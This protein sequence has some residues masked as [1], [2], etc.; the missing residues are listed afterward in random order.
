MHRRLTFL[1]LCLLAG[2][3]SA[4]PRIALVPLVPR[5]VVAAFADGVTA[6]LSNRIARSGWCDLLDGASIAAALEEL[7]LEPVELLEELDEDAELESARELA[8]Y[9]DANYLLWG[10]LEG[11]DGFAVRLWCLKRLD[12]RIVLQAVETATS[13][14]AL[15]EA[16]HQLA[17]RLAAGPGGMPVTLP[18]EPP[19]PRPVDDDP[20][21]LAYSL[22]EGEVYLI[23][24]DGANLR[25]LTLDMR[26]GDWTPTASLSPD[27]SRVAFSSAVDGDGEIY[28][29][30]IDGGFLQRLTDNDYWDDYPSW[31]ADGAAVAYYTQPADSVSIR[32]HNLETGE[33]RELSSGLAAQRSPSWSPDGSL[34]A[35]YDPSGAGQ[36]SIMRASAS[37]GRWLSNDSTADW[38]PAWH[39]AGTYIAFSTYTDDNLELYLVDEYGEN[40][41]RLTENS[42]RDISPCFSGDGR[43]LFFQQGRDVRGQLYSLEPATGEIRKLTLHGGCHP[44]WGPSWRPGTPSASSEPEPPEPNLI[45]QAPTA[46][47]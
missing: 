24:A 11:G 16:A 47:G 27:G 26:A 1:L 43:F 23:D 40:P 13:V 18:A 28:V 14:G 33:E 4:V 20:G 25:Q 19:R 9:L 32:L 46:D 35:F 7:D 31:S 10:A 30:G 34:I 5:E 37:E 6:D 15:G 2:T 45:D 29:I 17:R 36:L 42:V 39:P 22:H 38:A 12:G 44:S 41:Q 8:H 3:T 21:R